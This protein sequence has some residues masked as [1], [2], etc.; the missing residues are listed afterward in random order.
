VVVILDPQS[1]TF[2]RLLEAAKLRPLQELHKKR[3]PE[4]FNFSKRHRVVGPG[5]DVLDPVF[6]QLLL[7]AGLAPPVGVLASVVG[8]NFL[9]HP[10]VGHRP[11]VGLKHVLGRLAAVHP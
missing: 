1:G 8:Q 9:G 7:E 2:Q 6:L 4:A 10:V 11:P 3:L 5:T